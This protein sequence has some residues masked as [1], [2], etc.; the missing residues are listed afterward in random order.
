MRSIEWWLVLF[1]VS[2]SDPE[3]P[4]TTP[5]LRS[6]WRQSSKLVGTLGVA[7]FSPSK[8]SLKGAWS[9]HMSHLNFWGTNHISVTAE[10]RV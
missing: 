3:L 6:W 10:A 8:L 2:L 4:Q 1:P 9:V 5:Y 7:S